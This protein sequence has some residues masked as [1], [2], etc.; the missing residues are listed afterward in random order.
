MEKA[1]LE[2]KIKESFVAFVDVLGFSHLIAEDGG[3][4]EK[5]KIIK[6][7][8]ATATGFL[9]E[10]KKL[11][12]HPY[13][14][15]Y[16]EFQVKS[17]SDCFCFSI[18][19][20]F[21]DGEK[22]YKQ[23]FISFYV[24]IKAFCNTLLSKG[25]LCRGGI[26]QGWHYYDEKIIFSQALVE[27]YEL[28][29]KKANHPLILIHPKLINELLRRD[30]ENQ[31]YYQYM[32]VHDTAG[33]SFLHPFNYSI[34]DELFFGFHKEVDK[35]LLDERRDMV[36]TFLKIVNAK[37]EEFIGTSAI[38]KWQ[39]MKDFAHFTLFNKYD[40]RFRTGLFLK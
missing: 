38:D 37:I 33:K 16:K 27:A 29:S 28:E 2:Y 19:L 40:D 1:K 32:F 23:N 6:D 24:W 34:V 12:S 5:L 11:P 15:W 39:W 30:I 14:F 13:A 35:K 3:Q 25:F 7:A 8:I 26:T 18:P 20:E 17:F 22:D 31:K 36:N 21:E 9:E 10:R 4:G